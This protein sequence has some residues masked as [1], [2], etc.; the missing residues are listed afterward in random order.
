[1]HT[2]KMK[3]QWPLNIRGVLLQHAEEPKLDKPAKPDLLCHVMI[4][5]IGLDYCC[6]DKGFNEWS[7][8]IY[9]PQVNI[10]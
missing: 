3:L 10:I 6:S 9:N 8:D 1:M 4:I 2:M 7:D 5:K